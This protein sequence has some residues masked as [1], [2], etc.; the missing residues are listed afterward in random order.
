MRN[1]IKKIL[2]E[3]TEEEV[4]PI[5]KMKSLASKVAKFLSRLEVDD[6]ICKYMIT[7]YQV[8]QGGSINV[9]VL[10]TEPYQKEITI[11][12]IKLKVKTAFKGYIIGVD[13][14]PNYDNRSCEEFEESF[15][16]YLQRFPESNSIFV[17]PKHKKTN[18]DE[19]WSEKYKK[20]IDCSN[21]KGFSQRAHCQGR[22]KR[23][24][25]E[26]SRTLKMAR[27]QGSGTR[28]PKSALKS[29]P[30]RFREYSRLNE[31]DKTDQIIKKGI[32][33]VIDKEITSWGHNKDK[34]EVFLFD[35]NDKC[36]IN[37]NVKNKK[38][39]YD[40][41]LLDVV[42][43]K[44]RTKGFLGQQFKDVLSDWFES[45]FEKY[46]YKVDPNKKVEGANI[47]LH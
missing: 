23:D 6:S 21:P 34:T 5:E 15:N 16:S 41:H 27:R 2:I 28:F 4:V 47:H 46:E 37:Y 7:P 43:K 33:K 20:S 26:Y 13:F 36:L 11:K 1:L 22:K 17:N 18:L 44:I 40:H 19:K 31:D 30:M 25:D 12:D 32:K 24:L 42:G 9:M 14:F 45:N 35:N 8:V 38:L 39:W 10:S 29:N 3:K